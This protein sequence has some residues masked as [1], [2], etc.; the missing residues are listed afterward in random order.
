MEEKKTTLK[1]NLHSIISLYVG[2]VLLFSCPW[3]AVS[4]SSTPRFLPGFPGPLPFHLETGYVGVGESDQDQLFYYFVQSD[5][6][7]QEDP[8]VLWLTGGP[9]CSA[10]SGLVYEIGPLNFETAQ[11]NGSLPTF[12]LNPYSWTKVSN[13][14]FLDSPVWT[15]FSYSRGGKEDGTGDFKSSR[16][17]NQFLRKWLKDH[18]QF[19]TNPLYIGGDSYS[20][21]TVPIV[22]QEIANGNEAGQE[23]FLNLK[24][25]FEGNPVT[26]P[27][28]D[29][30]AFVP[31]IHGMG[32]I[33]DE[34]F[35]SAKKNCK[36]NYIN[37]SNE[38]C[39]NDLQEVNKCI[40]GLNTAQLLEPLCF[41]ASPKPKEADGNRRALKDSKEL[42]P[43]PNLIDGCRTAGYVLSYYWANDDNVRKALDIHKGSIKEWVRC[44]YGLR[45][46]HEVTSVVSY[47]LNLT[48]RGYRALIYSGDHDATIPFSGTHAWI[49]SLNFSII[50]DWRSWSVD[51]QIGG[52]TRT[53]ANNITFATIKGAGHTAPE[54]K[55]K[56]GFAMFQRWI[57]QKP[58]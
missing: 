18:P 21:I 49:R 1:G 56:E 2:L 9:G 32:I 30:N 6:N 26:D 15:G 54:Y 28:F 39:G 41:F 11:Y 19:L 38:E 40:L 33:S 12:T 50:D 27:E 46:T 13:I 23:L 55:P 47:H 7:P 31:Y 52:Y 57:S 44:N 35:E 14:I 58:L 36:G 10:W 5:T 34:L 3:I 42:F 37:P 29:G 8:L 24:G 25:Y 43:E 20:G 4:Q 45:F 22:T 17:I 48:T 51:G 53:F 16:E